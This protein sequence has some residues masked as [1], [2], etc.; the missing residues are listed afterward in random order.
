MIRYPT[1]P[2]P[3]PS[4]I[5]YGWVVVASVF[6]MH[7]AAASLGPSTF[8][9]FM[10]DM[11]ADLGVSRSAL[12]LAVTLRLVVAGMVGPLV[13][14]LV[15][16]FG[17]R[18]LGMAAGLIGAGAVISLGLVQ[19]LWTLYLLSAI[20]GLVAIG[21]PGSNIITMVPVA[22]WFAARRGRAMAI[23]TIGLPAGGAASALAA[24]WLID[25]FDWR[26]AWVV[27]GAV[28]GIVAIPISFLFLRGSPED[29]GV[30]LE[31][32]STKR[33]KTER[34]TPLVAE[35]DWTLREAVRTR[36]LWQI[37]I[38]MGV[39]GFVVSGMIVHR[40]AFWQDV[41]ITS[42]VLSLGIATDPVVLIFTAI[43]FG[44]F[45]E[46]I[47]PRALGMVGGIGLAVAFI[48][49]VFTNGEVYTIFLSSGLWG[50]FGGAFLAV[51]NL[52]LPSYFGRKHLGSIRGLITP[53]QVAAVGLGAPIYGLLFDAGVDPSI[54][55]AGS[56]GI[57]ALAG[58]LLFL[59]S[60]PVLP[61][62]ARA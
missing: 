8:S 10:A 17:P 11:G 28:M 55:W 18:W 47:G 6:V 32:G 36:T 4:R 34:A 44:V 60:R 42:G 20:T 61:V 52:I 56:M 33:A 37:M 45:G 25:T 19:H 2:V 16:R 21:G 24:T 9:F 59:T 39:F 31:E 12:S 49:M 30:T 14:I 46:R 38:A 1:V 23:A 57:V 13:G 22:K 5:Y 27:Y 15:D 26:G 29:L 51:S 3:L 40:V 53:L 48:P 35:R 43:R 54:V 41:G 50:F 7:M 62:G 58:A